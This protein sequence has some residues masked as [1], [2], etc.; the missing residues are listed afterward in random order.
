[1]SEWRHRAVCRDQI[2]LFDQTFDVNRR[3]HDAAVAICW[4][5]PVRQVCLEDA[6]D[7]EMRGPGRFGVRGGLTA[8]DR[9]RAIR[10]GRSA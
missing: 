1:M 3:H 6:M 2:E 7:Y 4:Q 5:C 10:L 8:R 9:E